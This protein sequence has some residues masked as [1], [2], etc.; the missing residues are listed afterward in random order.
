MIGDVHSNA[1]ALN[2]VLNAAAQERVDALLITGDLV[3]YYFSARAVINLLAPWEKFVVR[4]NHEEMLAR[5]RRE[6]ASGG[7]IRRRYGSGLDIVLA[8]LSEREVDQLCNLPH[9]LSLELDGRKILLCHGSPEDLDRYVYPDSDLGG[10]PTARW[11]PSI[12]W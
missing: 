3:G 8:Q 6:P 4:G 11:T 5:L 1:L 2:T 12:W 10:W 7:E 9:P